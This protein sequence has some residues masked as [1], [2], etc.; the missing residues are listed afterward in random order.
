MKRPSVGGEALP[1]A[2][3]SVSEAV[4]AGGLA[5]WQGV[6]SY[7]HC[8]TAHWGGTTAAERV[9]RSFSRHL[10]GSWY[11]SATVLDTGI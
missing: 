2:L 10:L 5:V 7:P 1:S 9:T 8:H 4:V 11:V 6:Q 3:T